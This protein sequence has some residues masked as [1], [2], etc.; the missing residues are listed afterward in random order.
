MRPKDCPEY[1]RTVSVADVPSRF[2]QNGKL[3][4]SRQRLKQPRRMPHIGVFALW[5]RA[6][7]SAPRRYSASGQNTN[8][9]RTESNHS[10]FSTDPEFVPKV[11]D[12]V[13]LYLDPPDRAIVLSVDEKSQVQALD[14]TQPILPLRPVYRP[15]RHM[16][17]SAMAQPPYLPL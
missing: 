5:R 3:P 11:R 15:V 17:T 14:R 1:L 7:K 12:I 8:Y 16:I 2:P 4:L 9:S 10:K 6:R 13:G